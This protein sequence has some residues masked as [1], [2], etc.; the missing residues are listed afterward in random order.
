MPLLP[1]SNEIR[2]STDTTATTTKTEEDQQ[3]AKIIDNSIGLRQLEGVVWGPRATKTN[4][5]T[6]LRESTRRD[7][8]LSEV[9]QIHLDRATAKAA[10][11][12]EK[13][14]KEEEAEQARERALKSKVMRLWR[15]QVATAMQA[16]RAEVFEELKKREEEKKRKLVSTIIRLWC[17][18]AA[19]AT[20]EKQ[21]TA[22]PLN[23]RH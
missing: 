9:I 5:F 22:T 2:S 18:Q 15:G 4:R 19:K 8:L 1:T 6:R 12:L 20:L 23:Q 16:A 7:P 13:K 21:N 17:L 10:E 11:E 3:E 14:K